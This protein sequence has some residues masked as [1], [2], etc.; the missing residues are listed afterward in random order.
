[1]ILNERPA[2][3]LV[4][5]SIAKAVRELISGKALKR[6]E[7]GPVGG[8]AIQ[9]GD[10][11]VGYAIDA[12]LPASGG[13]NISRISDLA[14]AQAAFQMSMH[15]QVWL[16]GI[17]K[18]AAATI[19]VSTVGAIGSIGPYHMDI[20]GKASDG[21]IRG[22][23][24]VVA[25]KPKSAPT[26]PCLWAH[27]ALRERTMA[28]D[29]DSE[30]KPLT[31]R[32]K[33]LQHLI[34]EKVEAV[35]STASHCHFN[36]DFR[37]NS[38]PTAMQ[39]TP[40]RSIGGRAWLSVSLPTKDHEKVLVAWGNTSLGLLLHWWHSNK[41]QVGRGSVGK[42]ALH[43]LPVLDIGALTTQQRNRAVAV[44]DALANKPLLP[45][46]EIDT[47]PVRRELDTQ[48][49]RDVLGLAESVWGSGGAMELLR[50]KLAREPSIRGHK[51]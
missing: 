32:T 5:A 42:S 11:V 51:V 25:V 49:A 36:R 27:D 29:A 38:Q 35:W 8:T 33:G 7:D 44:F 22:P 45:L 28:F 18:A 12:P 41:Q 39:F 21:G 46:H 31:A 9:F 16:P 1:V 23:F 50:A 2:F 43:G 6:L 14:L 40:R 24:S 30:A 48:F 3:S 17:S 15:G 26:Y 13:W 47:D 4:G 10:D 34:D 20:N 19:P 37:F